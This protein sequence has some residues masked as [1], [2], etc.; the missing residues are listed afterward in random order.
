MTACIQTT[1]LKGAQGVPWRVAMSPR[2][3]CFFFSTHITRAF[4]F[5]PS[6]G[7]P[8][9]A[10]PQNRCARSSIYCISRELSLFRPPLVGPTQLLLSISSHFYTCA[11]FILSA[12][13]HTQTC[14][15]FRHSVPQPSQIQDLDSPPSSS[16]FSP[17][18]FPDLRPGVWDFL[19][20][21]IPWLLDRL[22]A[23]LNSKD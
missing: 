18:P 5:S 7:R 2:A 3:R 10:S 4:P 16:T 20:P 8:C 13:A 21:A 12:S 14:D 11:P 15:G 22:I 17:A 1:S 23:A 6:S 9:S 19:R